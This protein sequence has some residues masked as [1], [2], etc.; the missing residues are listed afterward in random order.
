MCS[1]DSIRFTAAL[2]DMP[3]SHLNTGN[4]PV[5]YK[6]QS[7]PV[8]IL[9]L[10]ADDFVSVARDVGAEVGADVTVFQRETLDPAFGG[11]WGY[12]HACV[13]VVIVKICG[14]FDQLLTYQPPKYLL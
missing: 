1:Q 9:A 5:L 8:L 2:V 12:A 14:S 10:R 11:L 6:S 4:A 3:T 13:C 7:W